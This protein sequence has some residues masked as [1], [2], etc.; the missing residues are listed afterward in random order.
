MLFQICFNGSTVPLSKRVFKKFYNCY[1]STLVRLL[2]HPSKIIKEQDKQR[3]GNWPANNFNFK[4]YHRDT[5]I[6]KAGLGSYLDF[7]AAPFSS[8]P[9]LGIL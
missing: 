9:F 8:Q 3:S 1:G 5:N 4:F 2:T 7:N 6:P